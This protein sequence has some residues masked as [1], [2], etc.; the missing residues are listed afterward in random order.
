MNDK[1]YTPNID[2]FHVGFEFEFNGSDCNWN[3][4]G[5]EKQVILPTKDEYFDLFTLGWVQ[6][7]YYK[8]DDPLENWIRVKYLDKSDIEDLGFNSNLE[9]KQHYYK[10]KYEIAYREDS[11]Y[12]QVWYDPKLKGAM[13]IF[14]GY[15]K[16]ISELK[17]LL[18]QLGID[19]N[20]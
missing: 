1:Y 11:H 9:L 3:R 18:K 4:T 7:I 5:F 15:I 8:P 16:N 17:V 2:E 14:D 6:R 10:D 20:V 12:T 13:L 19:V